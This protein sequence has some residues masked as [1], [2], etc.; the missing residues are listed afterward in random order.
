LTGDSKDF[1]TT[2]YD[3][4]S[5]SM[6]SMDSKEL[7]EDVLDS[8]LVAN[9]NDAEYDHED[10]PDS[11]SSS[12][13]APSEEISSSADEVDDGDV[14]SKSQTTVVQKPSFPGVEVIVTDE[15]GHMTTAIDY[16]PR[17]LPRPK[18]VTDDSDTDTPHFKPRN[19][20]NLIEI[21]RWEDRIPVGK[22]RDLRYLTSLPNNRVRDID[23]SDES[24]FRGWVG[25][26]KDPRRDK[27]PSLFK[28]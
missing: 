3:Q 15:E 19:R 20:Q 9:A 27:K 11:S 24:L 1:C 28:R 4:R 5:V 18:R 22:K 23:T 14:T 2:T 17:D 10:A 26:V 12:Q 25:K 21:Q 13:D 16:F 7:A 6:S 8:D